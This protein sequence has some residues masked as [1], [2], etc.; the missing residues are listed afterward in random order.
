MSEF[1]QYN[2]K[3]KPAE[4]RP[5]IEGEDLTGVSISQADLDNWD[6]VEPGFISRNPDSHSDRWYVANKW[7]EDNFEM[8]EESGGKDFQSMYN[9]LVSEIEANYK[10]GFD[11]DVEHWEGGNYDDSYQYGF[12]SGQNDFAADLLDLIKQQKGTL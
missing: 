6:N 7:A 10:E 1:K 5:Y 8:N 2:R 12:D 9:D 11:Y 3:N 4:M